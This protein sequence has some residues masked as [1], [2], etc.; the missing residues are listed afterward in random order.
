MGVVVAGA[1]ARNRLA[2]LAGGLSDR[3]AIPAGTHHT[4]RDGATEPDIM[5][6]LAGDSSWWRSLSLGCSE[7]S[8]KTPP[9]KLI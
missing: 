6:H 3:N 4:W 5:V 7:G 9:R 8:Q 2:S 1:M